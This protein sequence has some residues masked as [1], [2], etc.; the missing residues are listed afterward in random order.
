MLQNK[1]KQLLPIY[2]I[3]VFLCS[4]GIQVNA[5]SKTLSA[6]HFSILSSIEAI[7]KKNDVLKMSVEHEAVKNTFGA[8]DAA[9]CIFYLNQ[10]VSKFCTEIE[11]IKIEIR[12][13]DSNLNKNRIAEMYGMKIEDLINSTKMS[14]FN[15]AKSLHTLRTFV[16]EN[17]AVIFLQMMGDIEVSSLFTTLLTADSNGLLKQWHKEYLTGI[18]AQ[19]TEIILSKYELDCRITQSNIIEVILNTINI[20]NYTF[21]NLV[22]II[23]T[24][25]GYVLVGEKFKA[26]I[27]LGAYNSNANLKMTV[28]G[29]PVKVEDGVG[30]F[31]TIESSPGEFYQSLTINQEGNP[32]N[33]TGTVKYTV[34]SPILSIS[35]DK[36]DDVYIGL[37]NTIYISVNGVNPKEINVTT[38]QGNLMLVQPGVYRLLINSATSNRLKIRVTVKTKD[39]N[40]MSFP[41]KEFRI[42]ALPKP[43]LK[44]G[45][46]GFDKPISLVEFKVQKQALAVLQS[47][48]FDGVAFSVSSY[49]FT[50]ITA[51]GKR[52]IAVE[53]NSL[54]AI[55]EIVG[56]LK[57]GDIIM[58]SDIKVMGPGGPMQLDNCAATLK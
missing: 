48:I 13:L 58:F 9:K 42:K 57:S 20:K 38:D 33:V 46:I 3:S 5:Q 18:S 34:Y 27:T 6:L 43:V 44:I 23:S 8:K 17:E 26:N 35:L 54:D 10:R 16:K 7:K 15:Y 47:F 12:N 37:E 50:A 1:L 32:R 51:E 31:E 56:K 40:T 2:I 52:V 11:E 45:T 29:N 49:T 19:E 4:K 41:R 55:Q 30:K 39:G 14:I 25:N 53:G 36:M 22:P 21:D 24:E 28:G